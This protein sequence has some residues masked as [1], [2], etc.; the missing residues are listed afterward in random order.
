MN[1]ANLFKYDTDTTDLAAGEVLFNQGDAGDF[2]FVVIEGALDVIIDGEIV[3]KSGVGTMLGEMAIIDDAPRS[4]TV[5]A[6]EACR[7]AKID[8]KRFNFIVQN[9][10]F[11]AKQVMKVLVERVR[12]TNRIR[13]GSGT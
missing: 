12:Q 3:E 6:T 5:I 2:M 9:N 11:F 8:E 1:P 4:A 10:P 7:L 13:S